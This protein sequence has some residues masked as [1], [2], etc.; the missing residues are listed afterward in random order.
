MLAPMVEDK[1]VTADF[2]PLFLLSLH[3]SSQSTHWYPLLNRIF[4]ASFQPALYHY[5]MASIYKWTIFNFPPCCLHPELPAR[6]PA[7]V[8]QMMLR[9]TDCT[10]SFFIRPPL[11]VLRDSTCLFTKKY[12]LNSV[13]LHCSRVRGPE[14]Q[15]TC[16]SEVL[17]VGSKGS[18]AL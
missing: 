4:F 11:Q 2:F 5:N 3:I 14:E 10:S 1:L 7:K 12:S 17:W 6:L 15:T 8:G 13:D 9:A 18:G 16:W